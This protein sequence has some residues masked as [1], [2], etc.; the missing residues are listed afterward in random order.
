MSTV[1]FWFIQN[2]Q[3]NR[4]FG[5]NFCA[6]FYSSNFRGNF[7]VSWAFGHI[8]ESLLDEKSIKQALQNIQDNKNFSNLHDS[9]LGRSRADWLVGINL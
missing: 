7:Y 5:R 2:L 4:N 8:L 6:I 3:K 1:F 9:A